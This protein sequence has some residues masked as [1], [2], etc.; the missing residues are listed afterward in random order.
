MRMARVYLTVFLG[1]LCMSTASIMIR[2]CAADALVIAFY[3]VLF[4]SLLAFVL[5]FRNSLPSDVQV[6]KKSFAYIIGAGF[7]LAF[8]FA[9]WI[10]S[11]DYTSV[12]SSVLFT[13]LQ[14]IFVLV[15]SFL[16]LKERL[17]FKA[18]TGII[19]ALTGSVFIAGGDLKNGRFLGDMLSLLSGF[20]IALYFLISRRIR[21]NV[22]TFFYMGLVSLTAALP[23]LFLNLGF[24][25]KLTGYSS[26]DWLWFILLALV[27]GIGGHASLTWALKYVKAPIVAVSVLGESVGA[28]VLA[29]I[30]FGENPL[31]YQWVGGI[32]I[33]IG[34]Y[35]AVLNEYKRGQSPV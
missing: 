27:P 5:S 17:S 28:S 21:N 2:L 32:L 31:W 26:L 24:D 34:I 11:L 14:V 8:H 35:T 33:I 9:F 4:T 1:V 19:I 23:L 6:I 13:N 12:S 7:F 15:F 16:F 20:F 3:R 10:T 22:E 30:F 29:Y 18:L 25:N